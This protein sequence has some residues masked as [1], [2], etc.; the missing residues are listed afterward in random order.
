MK[1]TLPMP[2]I[3]KRDTKWLDRIKQAQEFKKKTYS[4][5]RWDDIVR[6]YQN[7]FGGGENTKLPNFNMVYMFGR[8]MI[9]S[10]V[11]QAPQVVNTARRPEFIPWASAL[12]A[13]DNWLVEEMELEQVAKDAVL[14]S[15]LFNMGA[16]QLG[17]DYPRGIDSSKGAIQELVSLAY[18]FQK[19][20]GVVNRARRTNFPF[21][22]IIDPKKLI[23]SPRTRNTRTCRWFAHTRVAHTED[24]K[25]L[26]GK[27]VECT[28]IPD[29]AMHETE[30]FDK[31]S[32][33]NS[34]EYTVYYEIH[35]AV[36]QQMAWLSAE[37]DYLIGWR[38]DP[39]QLDGLPLEMLV[40]NQSPFNIW[41]TPDA[42]YIEGQMLDGNDCRVQGLKQRRVSTVKAFMDEALFS[43]EEMEKI[44]SDDAMPIIRCKPT[45]TKTIQEGIVL[46]APHTAQ[47][48]YAYQ[49]KLNED[50][51]RILGF[52][53]NQLGTF[54]S[55]R[56]TRYEVQV[57]EDRN[58]ARTNERREMAAGV[59]SDIMR[60]VN[61]LIVRNWKQPYVVRVIG[62]DLAQH[63]INVNPSDLRADA[64]KDELTTSIDVG[65]MAPV[66]FERIKQ[67]AAELL[68]MV[69]SLPGINVYPIV[70]QLLSKFT[71]LNVAEVMPA[72]PQSGT[73]QAPIPMQQFQQ[74]QQ[75]MLQPGQNAQLQAAQKQNLQTALP[76]LL[77]H[78]AQTRTGTPPGG[79]KK[80]IQRSTK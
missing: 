38:D 12:D 52:G 33:D 53:P 50:A 15:Y 21:V 17:W 18:G 74:Q 31:V 43:K 56:R 45:G 37:G 14:Y 23:L 46:I 6:Y 68:N 5:S 34:T 57:V 49:E 4:V 65:S 51:Q 19:V 75:A 22:E 44:Y 16:I 7:D 30:Y 61:Q 80:P 63:W 3:T 59:I 78:M 8:A 2:D 32:S 58:L 55:G 47:E 79:N 62:A 9:P 73:Q 26:L 71:W 54:A 10:I 20:P 27:D 29:D 48:N 41:G 60:K 1:E 69:G 13:I 39:L 66:S 25:K 67:E 77:H 76:T 28:H 24:L 42:L 35:D 40:F 36:T 11:F 72:A 64:L 70:R